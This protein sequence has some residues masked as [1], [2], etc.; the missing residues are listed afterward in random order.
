MLKS[1]ALQ[2]L[3]QKISQCTK[4]QELSELRNSHG[5]KTVPGIG[6][7]DTKI[8][9]LGEAPGENEALQGEPFVGRAGQLLTS[10]L[11]SIG[12]DRQDVYITN[13][14]KCRPPGNRDPEPGETE[15]CRKFL[16]M[17]IRCIQ[18]EWIICFGRIASVYLLGKE[19]STSIG[20]L[21]GQIHHYGNVKVVCTYH[22]AYA[23]RGGNA[24][25]QQ[26]WQDLQILFQ[27][28]VLP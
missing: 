3:D 16:D 12:L 11:K 10:I 19:P 14:L 6:N 23:L 26:I 15:N 22:P 20:G 7:P 21:R 17:Q 28:F 2:I 18:P 9:I 4:C 8:L 13:M 24:V 5:W 27:G 25:K 1:E